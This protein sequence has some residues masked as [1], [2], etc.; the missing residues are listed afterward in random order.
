MAKVRVEDNIRALKDA[1]LPTLAV[2]FS[3]QLEP[4][5]QFMLARI[6]MYTWKDYF[7]IQAY[8]A[9]SFIMGNYG[10]L[11][12][13]LDFNFEL[14][15][16]KIRALE[17]RDKDDIGFEFRVTIQ[18]KIT[19]PNSNIP[20]VQLDSGTCFKKIAKSDW[21]DIL[22]AVGFGKREFIS[23]DASI[24][25]LIEEYRRRLGAN[26]TTEDAILDAVKRAAK[27]RE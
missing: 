3:I 25:K 6:V 22:N 4:N 18:Y 2:P 24:H 8:V 20:I 17:K 11:A 26:A 5:A 23:V 12:Q 1:L 13:A 15:F 27:E 21:I 19:Y 7:P 14:P 16:D 9:E 10:V